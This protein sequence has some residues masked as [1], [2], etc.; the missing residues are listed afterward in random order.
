MCYRN[1]PCRAAIAFSEIKRKWD[2]LQL[3]SYSMYKIFILTLLAQLQTHYLWKL[4]IS[5]LSAST[6]V[7]LQHLFFSWSTNLCHLLPCL[8]REQSSTCD[9]ATWENQTGTSQSLWV[10]VFV[11]L[12]YIYSELLSCCEAQEHLSEEFCMQALKS[13]ERKRAA[14]RLMNRKFGCCK[15]LHTKW[16]FMLNC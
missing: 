12:I 7:H 5:S 8:I 3:W 9:I 14:D 2:Y 15:E 16:E 1:I 6:C 13:R 10:Y 4:L 11:C